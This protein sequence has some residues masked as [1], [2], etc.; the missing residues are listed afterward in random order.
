MTCCP[1]E[2]AVSWVLSPQREVRAFATDVTPGL[3]QTRGYAAAALAASRPGLTGDQVK[4]LVV[5]QSRR[6]QLLDGGTDVHLVLDEAVLRRTIGTSGIMAEQLQHLLAV[7]I[8]SWVRLQVLSFATPQV[9]V[10]GSFT[11]LSFADTAD[12]DVAYFSDVKGRAVR[13]EGEAGVQA[14]RAG[15]DQLS[16]AALSPSESVVLTK[17]LLRQ[18]RSFA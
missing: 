14:A 16:G 3:V 9:L 13:Q 12:S 1:P 15:F 6:Q 4:R 11:V 8:R 18:M 5:L 2:W 7:G 10:T 17:A